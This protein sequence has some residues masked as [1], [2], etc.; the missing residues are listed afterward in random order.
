MQ[1]MTLRA[2]VGADGMLKLEVPTGLTDVALDVVITFHPRP[3]ESP[4][5]GDLTS[6]IGSIED[7]T[8][9]R[10][11]QGDYPQREPLG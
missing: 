9:E 4:I 2:R 1:T 7:P 6:L 10:P 8:F 3:T 11:P 5:P